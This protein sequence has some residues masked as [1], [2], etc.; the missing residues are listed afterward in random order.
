MAHLVESGWGRYAAEVG[1]G[2]VEAGWEWVGV[3]KRKRKGGKEV[4]MGY[5]RDRGESVVEVSWGG[6]RVSEG[7]IDGWVGV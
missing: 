1:W 4:E 6:F 7:W 3:G 5:D 2:R